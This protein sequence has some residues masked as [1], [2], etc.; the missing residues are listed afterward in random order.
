MCLGVPMKILSVDGERA[1]VE[2]GGVTRTASLQLVENACAG[3]Y[4]IVHA[5]FAIERIDE[6]EAKRTLDLIREIASL[7]DDE[8]R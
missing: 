7:E 1:E 4:V 6:D 5:G 3:D 2:V 8:V